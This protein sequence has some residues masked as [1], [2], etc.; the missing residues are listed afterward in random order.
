M[1]GCRAVTLKNATVFLNYC[2][3]ENAVAPLVLRPFPRGKNFRNK[4]KRKKSEGRERRNEQQT[5]LKIV[6]GT[7]VNINNETRGHRSP[8]TLSAR[9]RAMEK[10]RI[11]AA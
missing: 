2:V 1:P 7:L 11:L 8:S 4:R 3:N 6:D 5:R 10:D 9:T